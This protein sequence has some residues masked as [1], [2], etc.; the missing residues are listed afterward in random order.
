MSET[1]IYL[2]VADELMAKALEADREGGQNEDY[3]TALL[4]CAYVT[5]CEWAEARTRAEEDRWLR[6]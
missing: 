3:V 2:D 4:E 6:P 5:L 1:D